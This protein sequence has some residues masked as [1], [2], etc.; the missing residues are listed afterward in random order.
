M[1]AKHLVFSIFFL[2]TLRIA[3]SSELSAQSGQTDSLMLI[4]EEEPCLPDASRYHRQINL[5]LQVNPDP[6]KRLRLYRMIAAYKYCEGELDSTIYYYKEALKIGMDHSIDSQSVQVLNRLGFYYQTSGDLDSSAYYLNLGLQLAQKTGDST[7]IG[8]CRIGLGTIYQHQGNIDQSIA[9]YFSAMEIAEQ[10]GHKNLYI[11]ARLNIATIYYDHQP[12]KLRSADFLELLKLTREIDDKIREVS[13]LE[14]LGYLKADSA[15][16]ESA[17]DYFTEGLKINE[18]IKDVHT[19]ILLLQGLAYVYDLSGNNLLSIETNNRI[20]ERALSKG[21]LLYLPTTYASN[22][23]NYLTMGKYSMVISEGKKAIE[24]GKKSSQKELYYKVL[25][26]MA[27][28]Y[29]ALDMDSEAYESQVEFTILSGEIFN[30]Q[31]SKQMAEV[32]TKY[33]TEK[34]E[35]EIASLSQQAA[36]QAL[37][38]SQ[39][40]QTMIIGLVVFILLVTITYFIYRNKNLRKERRQTELEQRFLRSQLNPHFI[41]NALLAIQNYMLR[42]DGPSAAL[43]LTKFSRLMREILESSR[44]EFIPVEDE[45]QMITNYLDI[46]QLRLN[47]AFDYQIDIS[48]SIHPETDTIPPMFVQP[49]VENAIEHGVS[50]RS[51]GGLI[52]VAFHKSGDYVLIEITDNGHGLNL[53]APSNPDHTSLATTIIKERMELFNKSLKRKIRLVFHEIKTENGEITGTTV[54]LKVPFG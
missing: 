17:I 18:H 3:H 10:I 45:V 11:T 1:K 48:E 27:I 25:E 51:E 12:E 36:I 29:K 16:Y 41:F 52:K 38:I 44:R 40:N 30:E 34:K 47:H 50:G 53:S 49:F 37:E 13:V 43:Y 46:H 33:E 4:L 23:S 20:I 28:A 26:N 35:T 22:A 15:D 2:T 54:E 24:A 8:A 39:K 21:Y 7:Y 9:E 6:E 31:K 32:Q 5:G 42:N 19:E 14:W